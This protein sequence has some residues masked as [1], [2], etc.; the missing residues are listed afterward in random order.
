VS[1]LRPS[2]R[3]PEGLRQQGAA[4]GPGETGRPEPERRSIRVARD[5][6]YGSTFPV[7]WLTA[8]LILAGLALLVRPHT[9]ASGT[10]A[11]TAPAVERLATGSRVP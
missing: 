9:R 2:L 1:R 10:D 8:L 6:R 3:L 11:N 5:A 7:R 4:V